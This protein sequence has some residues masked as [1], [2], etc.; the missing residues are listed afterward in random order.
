MLKRVE[1]GEETELDDQ[2]DKLEPFEN[3]EDKRIMF[4]MTGKRLGKQDFKSDTDSEP[5]IVALR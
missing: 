2:I 4:E 3:E 1:D 5:E